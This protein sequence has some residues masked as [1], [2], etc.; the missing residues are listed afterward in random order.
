MSCLPGTPCW[1]TVY[2]NGLIVYNTLPKDCNGETQLLSSD[3][4]YYAGS[5]LPNTGIQTEDT[6]SDAIEK[7]DQKL[8]P[9]A[10]LT[11]ILAVLDTNPTLKAALC[12]KLADCP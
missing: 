7:I 10:I 4:L 5:N 12:S 1:T 8:D 11:A 3:S 9:E 2:Q 6:L